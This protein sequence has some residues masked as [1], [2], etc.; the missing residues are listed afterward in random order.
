[1]SLNRAEYYT[2]LETYLPDN[3]NQLI[4]PQDVRTVLID[5]V[6]S[7][8]NFITDKELDATNIGSFNTRT[9]KIGNLALNNSVNNPA[10]YN[11]DNTA[12]GYYS[13]G[14]NYSGVRNT[15]LGSY[16]LGCNLYGDEN[17]SLGFLSCGAN[18][19]GS[20]NV[21][22][23][24][25][26]LIGNK[27]GDFNI[28]IGHGA[29]NNIDATSNYKFYLGS[30]PININ[31]SGQAFTH[32]LYGDL[33]NFKLAVAARSLHE[34]GTLQVSGSITPTIDKLGNLGHP[35]M[36]W[37]EAFIASGIGYAEDRDFIISKANKTA[38][39]QYTL[40][41]MLTLTSGGKVGVGFLPPSGNLGFMTV[42]G[43]LIPSKDKT[44]TLGHSDL[45][46][47]GIFGN[48]IVSGTASVN[49][50]QYVTKTECLYECKTLHLATSGLCPDDIFS[51]TVCGYLSDEGVDGAGFEVHTSGATYRRDYRFIYRAPDQTLSCLEQDNNYS[52]SRWESNVS[53]AVTSGN[54][55]G[56]QRVLSPNNLSLVSQSGCFGAFI[57]SDNRFTIAKSDLISSGDGYI[58]FISS[59][60]FSFNRIIPSGVIKDRFLSRNKTKGFDLSY[61]DLSPTKQDSFTISS[62][63]NNPTEERTAVTIL[64]SGDG[65]FGISNKTGSVPPET[66]FNVQSSGRCDNRFTSNNL[67]EVSIQMLAQSNVPVSGFEILYK[68]K[69]PAKTAQTPDD[70]SS[71]TVLVDFSLFSPSGSTSLRESALSIAENNFIGI[72]TT[73]LGDVRVFSPNAPLTISHSSSISGTISMA[74]QSVAPDATTGFGKIYVK[75]YSVGSQTHALYFKDAGGS[76]FRT[77]F[78][79]NEEGIY[80]DSQGNT[81]AGKT[82]H[83]KPLSANTAFNAALGS[84]ALASIISGTGNVSIAAATSLQTGSENVLIGRNVANGI[85]TGADKN[86]IVGANQ[87]NSTGAGSNNIIIGYNNANN[88]VSALN[89]MVLIGSGLNTNLA[90]YT[91][92]IGFGNSPVLTG[93]LG[94]GTRKLDVRNA[95]FSVWSN[96]NDQE[97]KVSHNKRGSRYVSNI[98]VKDTIN[99]SINDGLMS[100]QF[101][102]VNDY[103]RVLVDFDYNATPLSTVA[104]FSAPSPVRP[105]MG[106]SGDIKVLGAVRFSDGTF[107]DTATLNTAL[108]FYDLNDALAIGSNITTT[109]SYLAMSVPDS[110]GNHVVGRITLQSLSDYVGSGFAAVS[111][112]CNHVW[113]NAENSIS[114]TNNSSSVFIGC[115]V[116]TA[117][118]GWKHAVFIGT[119][120]GIE[121]QTPNVGLATDTPNV[122]IGYYAG[123]Y[124]DNTSDLISIGTNAGYSA[125]N[126]QGSVYIGTN[127]GMD[128]NGSDCI[129][130]GENSLRGTS[131]IEGGSKNIEIV[132]GLLD[133][134]RLLHASGNLSDRLNIQNTIAGDTAKKKISIGHA[135]LNPDAPLSV[136]RNSIAVP[137]HGENSYVQTWWCDGTRVAYIDCNGNFYGGT[138][139]AGGGSSVSGVIEGVAKY[140]INAPASPTTPTSGLIDVKDASWNTLSSVWVINKDKNLTIASGAY[141]QAVAVNGTY[142][143]QWVSCGA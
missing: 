92:N 128:H 120:A 96:L 25:Y 104:N 65:V 54:H 76:E 69:H 85:V 75:P 59:S 110:G 40:Q 125:Y 1:M 16:S 108:N 60:G 82:P 5:L 90:D 140:T 105:F 7:I 115:N 138:G 49:D 48:I 30:Y 8:P 119:N 124:A 113:S 86:T 58:N 64:H 142:R 34:Y 81:F 13:L 6:D 97:L 87:F 139:G 133:N 94:G 84:G 45:K 121:S 78:G 50:L 136:R 117:A 3:S 129:G 17:V 112:N 102:D 57:R 61:N 55:I 18:L 118:T 88:S 51:S 26:S 141:V 137:G 98:I 132:A 79:L 126:S 37:S 43:D 41:R 21:A 111:N 9:T 83:T 101:A 15:A 42:D 131:S 53:I 95:S 39:S 134:Q 14:A 28:A 116:A 46:W 72:G 56:T 127:A 22:V 71:N 122:C 10:T 103:T 63:S 29:G 32:L 31:N 123:A 100:I 2:S 44:Y 73:R 130:I 106:V 52:R 35:Y 36:S 47:N 80:V 19:A 67:N 20:G 24:N 91:I 77:S 109:N 107:L 70:P 38:P 114:K 74:A 33:Q 99:T 23:G 66:I 143:F 68:P 27:H 135:T 4:S 93:S 11:E 89:N 62:V 12:V